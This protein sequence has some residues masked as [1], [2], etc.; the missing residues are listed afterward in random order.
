MMEYLKS[1]EQIDRELFGKSRKVYIDSSTI[2]NRCPIC[3]KNYLYRDWWTCKE[4]SKN[5]SVNDYVKELI[6]Y[7][8]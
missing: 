4:C 5:L 6:K 8:G 2:G 7:F 3:R 1:L